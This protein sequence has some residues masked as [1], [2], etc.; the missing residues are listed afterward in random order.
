MISAESLL[1][2]GI[3]GRTTGSV[4]LALVGRMM[5]RGLERTARGM[6]RKWWK[7]DRHRR[8]V[9]AILLAIGGV[10]SNPGPNPIPMQLRRRQ[11]VS[12]WTVY[13]VDQLFQVA[14]VGE[15]TSFAA[16]VSRLL[17]LLQPES[18]AAHQLCSLYSAGQA[19]WNA[20]KREKERLAAAGYDFERGQVDAAATQMKATLV[21]MTA[22]RVA[23][24]GP[25]GTDAEKAAHIQQV[26]ALKTRLELERQELAAAKSLLEEAK[27]LC[28]V[29]KAS[30]DEE[31]WGLL[32]DT[33]KSR[34]VRETAET[35]LDRLRL[36]KKR[37]K[38]SWTDF[39]LRYQQMAP[40]LAPTFPM[41]HTKIL[42]GRLPTHLASHVLGQA[43]TTT[44]SEM[45]DKL[46]NV[47][48]WTSGSSS[49]TR[50]DPMDLGYV[51]EDDEEVLGR[52]EYKPVIIDGRIVYANISGPKTLMIAW[53]QLIRERKEFKMESLRHLQRPEMRRV[54][55]DIDQ[56]RDDIPVRTFVEPASNLMSGSVNLFQDDDDVSEDLQPAIARVSV[57][58]AEDLEK[59]SANSGG[60][61]SDLITPDCDVMSI[62]N[63][64]RIQ[65]CETSLHIPV[66]FGGK[67]IQALVD[68]GATHQFVQ[69]KLLNR[70]GLMQ[71]V[72]PTNVRV[73]L[74]DGSIHSLDGEI[75]LEVEIGGNQ[76]LMSAYVLAGKGPAFVMGHPTFW[77]NEW[78]IDIRHKR[79]LRQD[80]TE[81]ARGGDHSH[82]EG[83]DVDRVEAIQTRTSPKRTLMMA[84]S[85]GTSRDP[86]ATKAD[87]ILSELQL[88]PKQSAM[89]HQLI[90]QE[91]IMVPSNGDCRFAVHGLPSTGS[92]F[93][94]ERGTLRRQ[95]GV[96][97]RYDP[98]QEG[99]TG[100]MIVL[101]NMRRGD[102]CIPKGI[103]YATAI[104][105][106]AEI[107]GK[108]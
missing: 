71:R 60:C 16:R 47:L 86:D 41:E 38:E 106:A 98:A 101:T 11:L 83:Q 35:E 79:I 17:Q 67:N 4:E 63:C 10:E 48:Y 95:V 50:P 76:H 7:R 58:T 30:T 74:A 78:L 14:S 97:I 31:V 8:C 52:A 33:V 57:I 61:E 23:Q 24:P 2:M 32:K 96:V 13:N 66:S 91:D 104:W 20:E 107:P 26:Q 73:K 9:L 94:T 102:V 68:T 69:T 84:Q 105:V 87:F 18:L 59:S 36:L 53:K 54:H 46:L 93:V 12:S 40:H 5:S 25:G 62:V 72:R 22:L 70:L 44:L 85:S 29:G 88:L 75:D 108:N 82:E 100:G 56:E 27:E 103:H 64:K 6:V 51:E 37:T 90:M 39:I 55:L 45:V 92:V 42:L 21:E 15:N 99:A 28:P 1:P 3:E 81:V 65:K 80:H 49:D 43:R 89:I 77:D 34:H 19:N